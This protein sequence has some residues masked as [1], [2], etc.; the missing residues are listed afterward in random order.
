M[1]DILII[2]GRIVNKKVDYGRLFD[3]VHKFM[4]E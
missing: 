3:A 2:I 4:Y 1:V